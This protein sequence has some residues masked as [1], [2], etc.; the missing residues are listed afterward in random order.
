MN[1]LNTIRKYCVCFENNG[2][3]LVMTLNLYIK[4][5]RNIISL[6]NGELVK[7]KKNIVR[8]RI[9]IKNILQ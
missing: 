1:D 9:I 8:V 5:L 3:I 6:E 7:N 4:R 2:Q